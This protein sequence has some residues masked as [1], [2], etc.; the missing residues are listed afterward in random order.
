M[1][2][3]RYNSS[4]DDLILLLVRFTAANQI[5]KM[6]YRET[7][8]ILLETD[9]Y[10][11]AVATVLQWSTRFLIPSERS[12]VDHDGWIVTS[13]TYWIDHDGYI[14]SEIYSHFVW[15][16]MDLDRPTFCPARDCR[17]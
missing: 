12:A 14:T 2:N 7:G 3:R 13:G 11:I 17:F 9:P 5:N 15:P 1:Y 16:H 4:N 6:V 10:T 8:N